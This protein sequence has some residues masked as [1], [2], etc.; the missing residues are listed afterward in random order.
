MFSL[1]STTYYF[2]PKE[3]YCMYFSKKNNSHFVLRFE[4]QFH[5]HPSHRAQGFLGPVSC[6]AGVGSHFYPRAISI[7]SSQLRPFFH[8]LLFDSQRIPPVPFHE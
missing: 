2:C 5:G 1:I 3:V 8:V 7:Y 4:V 6:L